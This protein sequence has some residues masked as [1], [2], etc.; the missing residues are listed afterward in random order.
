MEKILTNILHKL[1]SIDGRLESVEGRLE[2]LEVGQIDLKNEVT[3]FRKET[4]I[5]FTNLN[6]KMIY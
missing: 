1:E 4:S 5:E 3:D 2:T 6:E